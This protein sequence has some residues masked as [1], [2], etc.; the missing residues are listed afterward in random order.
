MRHGGG[1]Y[2]LYRV[3]VIGNEETPLCVGLAD[4][5]R[6]A[7]IFQDDRRRRRRR[8]AVGISV[9]VNVGDS[10]RRSAHNRNLIRA[11]SEDN[12]LAAL[13]DAFNRAGGN[14]DRVV[15]VVVKNQVVAVACI[16]NENVVTL[17]AIEFVIALAARD[18]VV[19]LTAR[20]DVIFLVGSDDEVLLN[21]RRIY[22]NN[23]VLVAAVVSDIEIVF[24]VSRLESCARARV[25]ELHELRIGV[26]AAVVGVV[27]NFIRAA[28]NRYLVLARKVKD[29]ILLVFARGDLFNGTALND[30]LVVF[31]VVGDEVVAVAAPNRD[32][33]GSICV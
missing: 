6:R 9:G 15:F 32:V 16:P 28:F 10:F 30:D 12:I 1:V 21:R 22:R 26:L 17:A 11:D 24:N 14:L 27:Y 13:L 2:F 7:R 25:V 23:V 20:H 18:S 5:R 8:I 31:R 29:E 33:F 3:A 4:Y 19:A